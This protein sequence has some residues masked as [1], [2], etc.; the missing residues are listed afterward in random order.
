MP[1]VFLP[2]LRLNA[3]IS[4]PLTGAPLVMI[5]ALGTDLHIWDEAIPL[6]PP[7]A[8]FTAYMVD[9][10]FDIAGRDHTHG[11]P[12][13]IAPDVFPFADAAPDPMP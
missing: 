11:T 6:L 5:H 7:E 13:F 10:T 8:G 12:S 3:E 2:D 9:M 4:G 1:P